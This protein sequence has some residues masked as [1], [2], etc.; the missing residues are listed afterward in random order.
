MAKPDEVRRIGKIAWELRADVVRMIGVGKAGHLGGSC[1]LAEIVAA[2]YFG[3][4][5]FDPKALADPN[6][7]RFL[8]SKGHSVLIQYAALVELG[9]IPREEL[10]KVKTLAGKLQGHPDMMTPGIEAVTGSLGQGLSIGVG[11][12]LA[13]RLA[14]RP[15]RVYVI[16]GDGEMAEGQLWEA[17]MAAAR[18]GLDSIAAILDR[19]RIQ[20][21]GPTKEIFDIP[22]LPE[23]WRAFGWNVLNVDGH[24]VGA[25]LDALDEAAAKKGAPTV[26]V[27]DTIKGKGVSFAENSAAFHN[28]ALSREQYDKA[29]AEIEESGR[30]LQ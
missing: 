9:V 11:M 27:A 18:Y 12:A 19:N 5:H 20:A 2:L 15:S 6:R 16:M 24:D 4:M 13:L 17:A 3:K 7:D 21:T 14:K 29:L 26:I 30:R 10:G 23:K 8:L 28:A 25:V 22:N 1:S